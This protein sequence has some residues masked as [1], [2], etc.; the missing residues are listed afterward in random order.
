M[1]I[2]RIHSMVETLTA[3]ACDELSQDIKCVDT[4]E[5]GAVVDM[6]KDLCKAEY[7]ALIA[8]EMKSSHH[9][10]ESET[11]E[12]SKSEMARQE[13]HKERTQ[14]NFDRF[15]KEL[16]LELVDI[17]NNIDNAEKVILKARVQTLLQKMG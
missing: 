10:D 16:M 17:W 13:Y 11:K 12:L 14:D 5:L 6:I 2:E 4:R 15:T 1:H 8:K 9:D 7:S 3:V